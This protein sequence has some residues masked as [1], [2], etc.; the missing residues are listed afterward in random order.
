MLKYYSLT[1]FRRTAPLLPVFK[2]VSSFYPLRAS[3]KDHFMSKY[4]YFT[5][6]GKKIANLSQLLNYCRQI[7][8]DVHTEFILQYIDD[9]TFDGHFVV[10]DI[11]P[12]VFINSL[13]F[14]NIDTTDEDDCELLRFATEAVLNHSYCYLDSDEPCFNHQCNDCRF[15]HSRRLNRCFLIR[16]KPPMELSAF[17]REIRKTFDD[18]KAH[19]QEHH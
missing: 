14:I 15:H 9:A 1:F 7:S 18:A 2:Y 11:S 6:K 10:M 13:A 5:F 4:D 8:K 19:E 12:T 17:Y 3:R 16:K